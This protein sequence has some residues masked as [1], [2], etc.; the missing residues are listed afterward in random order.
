MQDKEGPLDADSK[1]LRQAT[2]VKKKNQAVMIKLLDEYRSTLCMEVLRREFGMDSNSGGTAAAERK[3]LEHLLA[4]EKQDKAAYQPI[5][6]IQHNIEDWFM[7]KAVEEN[8]VPYVRARVERGAII[9]RINSL[10]SPREEIGGFSLL[11]RVVSADIPDPAMVECLLDAG[12]DPNFRNL[13]SASETPWI[14]AVTKSAILYTLKKTMNPEE[15]RRAEESWRQILGLLFKHG[16]DCL[17]TPK[18]RL[19]PISKK[20][21]REINALKNE[22][23][24]SSSLN[25]WIRSWSLA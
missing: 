4:E 14:R 13:V 6:S 25:D 22:H 23:S 21:L 9:T 5:A 8:I 16:A 12:A 1:C 15:Y 17:Q 7:L 18:S 3:Q 24:Q 10:Y 2:R 19:T 11:N 20:I